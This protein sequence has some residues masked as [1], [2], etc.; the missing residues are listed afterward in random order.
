MFMIFY[1][2]DV[3]SYF[4]IHDFN[5]TPPRL[6]WI[7]KLCPNEYLNLCLQISRIL[8]NYYWYISVIIRTEI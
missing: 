5:I 3:E 7:V 6:F 1:E 2:F 8:Y 4:V